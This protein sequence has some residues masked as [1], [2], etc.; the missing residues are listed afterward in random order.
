MY[1]RVPVCLNETYPKR[2]FILGATCIT[3]VFV[4]INRIGF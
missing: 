1:V 3:M 4:R 2:N